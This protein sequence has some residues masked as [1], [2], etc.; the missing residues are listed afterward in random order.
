M[1]LDRITA[2]Y[3]RRRGLS[4]TDLLWLIAILALLIAILLPSLSRAR[5]ITKRAVCAS[6]LRG[7]GQGIKIYSN[8]NYDWWPHHYY[9]AET[10]GRDHGVHWIGTMGSHEWLKISEPSKESPQRNHPSRALFMLVID[11]TCT[12]MQFIC[13][14][15]GDAED[16][17]RNRGPDA[18]SGRYARAAQPGVNRFDFRG[19]PYLS[20]GYQLPYGPDARPNE[21]LDARMIMMADKGPYFEAGGPGLA[22]SATVGDR[23]S[24]QRVPTGSSVDELLRRPMSAWRPY[25]SRNHGSEGQ[26]TLFVDGHVVFNKRPIEGVSYDNIYTIQAGHDH[27]SVLAGMVPLPNQ[28]PGPLTNTDSFIVP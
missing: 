2:R 10:T 13:P 14:S 24:G 26:N 25:N 22:E 12:T 5:E 20:Y 9:E 3:A 4:L 1:S 28:T 7:I 16:D 27:A 8:D 11:G 18:G 17:L 23:P 19:Y 6:N 21:D 15:S